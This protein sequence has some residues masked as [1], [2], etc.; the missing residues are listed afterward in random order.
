M[1]MQN[2]YLAFQTDHD[3][4]YSVQGLGLELG[5]EKK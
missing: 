4:M 2:L 3:L 5:G 1:G